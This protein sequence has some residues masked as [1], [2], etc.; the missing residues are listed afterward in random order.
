MHAL[1]LYYD[2]MKTNFFYSMNAISLFPKYHHKYS[3]EEQKEY[4]LTDKIDGTKY[5]LII[6]KDEIYSIDIN[7]NI[8]FVQENNNV[9]FVSSPAIVEAELVIQN[10]KKYY[11]LYDIFIL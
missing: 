7:S 11:F 3:K 9:C 8:Q 5:Q 1:N 2:T 4:I 6:L 10:N